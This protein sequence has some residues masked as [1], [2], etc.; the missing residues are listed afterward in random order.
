MTVLGVTWQGSVAMAQV[1]VVNGTATP[2]PAS[3]LTCDFIEIDQILGRG[4]QRVPALR[5]GERTTLA[6][7]AD[8]RGQLVDRVL[9][10]GT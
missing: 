7:T 5:Q 10:T 6:V 1:E 2:A 8:V 9:C 4:V 3:N